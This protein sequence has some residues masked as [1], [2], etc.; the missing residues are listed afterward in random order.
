MAKVVCFLGAKGGVGTTVLSSNFSVA[1]SLANYRVLLADFSYPFPG[2]AA[3]LLG[4]FLSKSFLSLCSF[5]SSVE[6]SLDDLP[7]D[8][9]I[10]M[11]KD[12]KVTHD[13]SKVDLI[14][15][16]A[17]PTELDGVDI[18]FVKRLLE[19]V[20]SLYDFVIVDAGHMFYPFLVHLFDITNL[21]LLVVVP[22]LLSSYQ[23]KE[24]VDI[25]SRI[26]VPMGMVKL[27][28][29]RFE[30]K[31]SVGLKEMETILPVP[32]LVKIPS[33]GRV[34]G[35][36]V[37]FGVPVVIQEPNSKISN[38][39]KRFVV[40][41]VDSDI[42]V[43]K[44]HITDLSFLESE[45]EKESSSV[46]K[47]WKEYGL[48]SEID[49]SQE[50]KI[51]EILL[52]KKRVHTKLVEKMEFRKLDFL[53]MDFR[54][55]KEIRERTELLIAQILSEEAGGLLGD[56]EFRKRLVKEIT[57]EALG[58]G[59][60]EDLLRDP[61]VTDI[62]VNGRGQ[63]Y[64]ER[65]GKLERV[66]GKEFVSNDQVIQV[67]ERIIA[68]LG[69]R[70]DES[71][72]M[73]DARLPDGSRVNAIIPPLALNGPVLTIRKFRKEMYTVS[74]L[75]ELNTL[76]SQMAEF[77]KA[78]IISRCNMIISGGTGSGKT[79][80]LNAF[81]Q[82]IP[83]KERIITIEDAAE[84]RLHKEHW[85]RLESRPPN[86]EGKGEITIRDLFRN[87]LRMRPDRIIIGECR[88]VEALDMLQAMN[89]G[90]DGSLTTIHAN[91]T[92][93]VLARLDSMILMSGVELPI[94]AIREM[95]ASA[96]DI[97]VHTARLSDGSRKILQITELLGLEEDLMTI[98][99]RDIFVFVQTGVS[100]DGKILGEF[101]A[102]GYVPSFYDEILRRGIKLDKR[103]FE[104]S[105]VFYEVNKE[106][107]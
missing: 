36:S 45:L 101:T 55:R 17:N 11:L 77:L 25:L 81:S 30:S 31:G 12:Y 80:V 42:F 70:I 94:R 9:L 13:L 93:D 14:Q 38:A 105:P 66:E 26:Y 53:T 57:D 68:P 34:V 23:A 22:D 56:Y 89:T 44:K 98:K 83:D 76:N 52:L 33:D 10:E 21:L 43:T 32:V 20:F 86:I 61:D 64:V 7:D 79:T 49:E 60:L 3:R 87:T 82:Y 54:K 40:T 51:D 88:G 15:F 73:V 74:D 71:V 100:P 59:P 41:F 102:T 96:I 29:N 78:C 18:D 16:I 46:A 103:I 69:R 67:I 4:A 1:L 47:F 84:L 8:Q 28:V 58:F 39:I 72:P 104:P 97:I 63:I 35:E 99:M 27:V 6:D 85:V 48:V 24:K 106:E 92:H 5:V 2:D 91:S 19:R 107:R 90:H 62:M 95:V 37:N 75:V 50:Q 65:F